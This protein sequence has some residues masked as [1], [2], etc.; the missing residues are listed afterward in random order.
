M[1]SSGRE[2]ADLGRKSLARALAPP[3]R[4]DDGGE[5]KGA[6]GRKSGGEGASPNLCC[7]LF[8]LALGSGGAES[9]VRKKNGKRSFFLLFDPLADRA[10]IPLFVK[11]RVK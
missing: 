6:R 8:L 1:E 11:I 4:R 10:L 2:E 3:L 5:K 7:S 9:G